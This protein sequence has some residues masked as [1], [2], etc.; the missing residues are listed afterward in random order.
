MEATLN[1]CAKCYFDRKT[2][3]KATRVPEGYTSGYYG[4]HRAIYECKAHAHSESEGEA[5]GEDG[6][7]ASLE[8][9][10]GD[11]G[12]DNDGTEAYAPVRD[13]TLSTY[14]FTVSQCLC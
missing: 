11:K 1:K 7:K 5:Q 2:C 4:R 14:S 3:H 12:E 6:G 10:E 13:R 9:D 8:G